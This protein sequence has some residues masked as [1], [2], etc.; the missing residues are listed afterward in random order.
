MYS[1]YSCQPASL[2]LGHGPNELEEQDEVQES[3]LTFADDEDTPFGADRKISAIS[4][5]LREEVIKGSACYSRK[6]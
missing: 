4:V 5:T 2:F 1:I 6:N 3:V